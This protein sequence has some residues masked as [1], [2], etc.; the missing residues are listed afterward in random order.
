MPRIVTCFLLAM[1][2]EK[3]SSG[4]QNGIVQELPKTAAVAR[5]ALLG[6]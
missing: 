3:V 2:A 4:I 1:G 6:S 5:V